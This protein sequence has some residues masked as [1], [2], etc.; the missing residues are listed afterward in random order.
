MTERSPFAWGGLCR[1]E[2][3]CG[4]DPNEDDGSICKGLP[5]PPVRPLVEVV[6]IDRKTGEVIGRG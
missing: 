6:L 1:C 4:D 2:K 3:T 5:P